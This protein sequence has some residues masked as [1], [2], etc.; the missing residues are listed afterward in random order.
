MSPPQ[1]FIGAGEFGGVAR[2]E[3][4]LAAA[5]YQL[6]RDEQAQTA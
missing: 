4:H 6:V 2:G 3:R 1:E 5:A